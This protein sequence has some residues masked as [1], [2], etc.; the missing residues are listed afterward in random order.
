MRYAKRLSDRLHAPF[1]ALAVETARSVRLSEVE[2]DRIAD[3][4]RL[5]QALGRV[6]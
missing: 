3:T 5:A 2:R 1:V 6:H 4:L